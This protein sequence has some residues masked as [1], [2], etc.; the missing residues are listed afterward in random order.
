M[1]GPMPS[2]LRS[3]AFALLFF[4]FA[5]VPTAWADE[6]ALE[7]GTELAEQGIESYFDGRFSVAVVEIKAALAKLGDDPAPGVRSRADY[8]AGRS[9]RELGLRG[10][11]LHYLGRAERVTAPEG[12]LWKALAQREMLRIYFEAGE[13]SAVSQLFWRFDKANQPGEAAYLAGMALA[14]EGRWKE[15]D[16][17]LNDVPAT[18]PLAPYAEFLHAQARGASGDLTGAVKRLERFERSPNLPAG[19]G[20]QARILRGKILFLLGREKEGRQAFAAVSGGGEAGLEAIRGLL[21]TGAGARAAALVEFSETRPTVAA[22]GMLVRARAADEKGDVAEARDVRHRLRTLVQD[23]RRRI[24]GLLGGSTGAESLRDDL[25]KFAALLRRERWRIRAEQEEEMLESERPAAVNVET[26]E[27]FTPRD[28]TFHEVWNRARS[29]QWMRGVIEI[30]SHVDQLDDESDE[31]VNRGSIWQRLWSGD[32]AERLAL[33]LLAIRQANLRQL[34]EDHLFTFERRPKEELGQRKKRAL[35]ATVDT[36]RALYVGKAT[37][38]PNSLDNVRLRMEYKRADIIR[39]TAAVPERST[40]PANSLLGNYVDLLAEL[41]AAMIDL[42]LEVPELDV[43]RV[44]FLEKTG[45]RT[46]ALRRDLRGELDRAMAP[47][48]RRQMAFFIRLDA[49]NEGA[50]SRLYARGA[51]EEGRKSKP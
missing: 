44:K 36:L 46:Q 38:L 26:F 16:K 9:C 43:E 24:D 34:F 32:D 23:R 2:V 12:R 1:R 18:D 19:L 20:D 4:C 30:L 22:T 10:L 47:E 21:L 51:A 3:F 41:R 11:A 35:E 14:M 25:S 39:L 50:L 42:D 33:S 48:L 13:F 27:G 7:E 8:F 6:A 31:A 49:D 5:L 15:A 45:R 28:G 40:S 37:G 17:V 29:D